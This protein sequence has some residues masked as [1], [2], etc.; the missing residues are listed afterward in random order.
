MSSLLP[1]AIVILFNPFKFLL[2]VNCFLKFH[3]QIVFFLSLLKF[4]LNFFSLPH[5][6]ADVIECMACSDN[7]VRAGLTPKFKD[8]DTLCDMLT[9]T[10]STPDRFRVAPQKDKQ[11]EFSE[12]YNPPI[13]EFTVARVCVPAETGDFTLPSLNGKYL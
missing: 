9:Y 3:S 4:L 12:I 8:K 13:P 11:S 7:V 6:G 2:S 10:A 1:A 5:T